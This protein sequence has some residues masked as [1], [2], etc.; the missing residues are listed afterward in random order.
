MVKKDQSLFATYFIY[1]Q[2]TTIILDT[3]NLFIANV[4][5]DFYATSASILKNKNVFSYSRLYF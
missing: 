2:I 1:D 5:N 4:T 3:N